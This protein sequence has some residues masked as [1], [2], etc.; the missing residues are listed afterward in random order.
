MELNESTIIPL[1]GASDFRSVELS[2]FSD[3]DLTTGGGNP[4]VEFPSTGTDV[5]LPQVGQQWKFN[6]PALM[7]AQMIQLGDSFNLGDFNDENART[8]FLYPSDTG[9]NQKSFAIDSRRSSLNVPQPIDC[10]ANLAAGGYACTVTINLVAPAD[11]DTANRNAYLRLSALYNKAHFR[12]ALK[13][14]TGGDVSFSNVQP[15][16]DSTGRA[17]D[18]FRRVVAR[19]E[20]R[21]DFTYPEAEITVG[22]NL[23]KNFTVTTEEDDYSAS[24]TCLP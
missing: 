4:G 14:S 17:N 11:G 8:L 24:S 9:A 3:K 10:E 20:L 1:R 15:E 12:V 16:V 5:H 7:R 19:I 13:D 2:W 6:H 18:L 21:S 23:C 22:G